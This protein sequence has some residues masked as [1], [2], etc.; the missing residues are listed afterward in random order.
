[1]NNDLVQRGFSFLTGEAK[2]LW[3][4]KLKA[5]FCLK[6]ETAWQADVQ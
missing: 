4:F 5:F 1:V 2:M 3:V 6:G